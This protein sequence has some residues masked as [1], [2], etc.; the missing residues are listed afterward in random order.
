MTKLKKK[1]LTIKKINNK[2]W[3]FYEHG[4]AKKKLWLACINNM[5]IKCSKFILIFL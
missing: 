4:L 3:I 5:E 1:Q 2:W